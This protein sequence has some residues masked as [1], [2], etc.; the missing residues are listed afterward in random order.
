MLLIE[1]TFYFFLIIIF[2]FLPKFPLETAKRFDYDKYL[3]CPIAV[4]K[5]SLSK[6]H[7]L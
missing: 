6:Q 4:A 1:S 3:L 5:G 2:I 7:Q